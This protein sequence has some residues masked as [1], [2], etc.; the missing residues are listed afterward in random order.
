MTHFYAPAM[1]LSQPSILWSI[2]LTHESF[3]SCAVVA[4]KLL[5]VVCA[6]F[7]GQWEAEL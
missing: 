6:A 3:D 5:G 2:I 4:V 7:A 1:Q